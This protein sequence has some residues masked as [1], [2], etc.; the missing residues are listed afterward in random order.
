MSVSPSHTK[1]LRQKQQTGA[2]AADLQTDA[3]LSSAAGQGDD[4]EA[5]QIGEGSYEGSRDYHNSIESYLE[6]ADVK[7]DAE[8]AKPASLKEALELQRAEQE[9]K[10]HSKAPGQ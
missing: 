7:S 6:H 3:N 9:G 5:Q 4:G 8:A 1:S 10:S 2:D